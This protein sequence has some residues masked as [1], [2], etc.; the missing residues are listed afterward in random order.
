MRL[1]GS[2]VDAANL[3]AALVRCC[4]RVAVTG[5]PGVGKSRVVRLALDASPT[6]PH[7]W[8]CTDS[9]KGMDWTAQRDAVLQVGRTLSRWVLEGVTVA[10]A[11]RHDLPVDVALVLLGPVAEDRSPAARRLG[12][13]VVSWARTAEGESP[14]RFV[15]FT[16]APP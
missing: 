10:R 1:K 3:L 11:L 13:S 15:W 4:D 8:V 7:T 14:G 12:D 16:L 5:P 2:V 6:A 9:Y